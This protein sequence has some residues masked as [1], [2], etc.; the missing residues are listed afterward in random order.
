MNVSLGQG[1][2]VNSGA[3]LYVPGGSLSALGAAL[4]NGTI[5][6]AGLTPLVTSAGTIL[7]QGMVSGTGRISNLTHAA[8]ATVRTAA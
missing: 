5:Q 2:T 7:N 4:N 3:L 8:G 6:L 1:L